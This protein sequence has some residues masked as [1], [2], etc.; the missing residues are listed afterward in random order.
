MTKRRFWPA[1]SL[2]IGSANNKKSINEWT[3]KDYNVKGKKNK[4]A[5]KQRRSKFPQMQAIQTNKQKEKE[6]KDKAK[7]EY[8]KTFVKHSGII[9]LDQILK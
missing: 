9:I 3:Q 4:K 1:F 2:L 6:M 8:N 5:N 7:D